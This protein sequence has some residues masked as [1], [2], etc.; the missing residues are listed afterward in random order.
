LW[1]IL[2]ETKKEDWKE[3]ARERKLV[4]ELE[5]GLEMDLVAVWDIWLE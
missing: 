4:D 5:L 3:V 2:K 1:E